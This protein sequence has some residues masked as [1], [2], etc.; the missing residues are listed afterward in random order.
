MFRFVDRQRKPLPCPQ[1][2]H[3]DKVNLNNL[4][5]K[6][7]KLT[8]GEQ[9]LTKQRLLSSGTYGNVY[10]YETDDKEHTVVVKE[11]EDE[12]D[13]TAERDLAQTVGAVCGVVHSVPLDGK[14]I[15]HQ[16]D[17]D[18]EK[19][20]LH[21]DVCAEI[22]LAIANMLDCLW[23]TRGVVYTDVK[24][25]NTLYWCEDDGFISIA[26]GDIGSMEKYKEEEALKEY[27][28]TF[29]LPSKKDLASQRT[30]LLYVE[31]K[32]EELKRLLNSTKKMTKEMTKKMKKKKIKEYKSSIDHL[33]QLRTKT[34]YYD[35]LE[36]LSRKNIPSFL[37]WQCACL[38]FVLIDEKGKQDKRQSLENYLSWES[39]TRYDNHDEFRKFR[40]DLCN[41]LSTKGYLQNQTIARL[42]E[43]FKQP[44]NKTLQ[45]L[46]H[47]AAVVMHSFDE[48]YVAGCTKPGFEFAVRGL[49]HGYPTDKV[50]LCERHF[51]SKLSDM[52]P[53]VEESAGA[54]LKQYTVPSKKRKRGKKTREKVYVWCGPQGNAE[55]RKED[56]WVYDINA[57]RKAAAA[58]GSSAAERYDRARRVP[59]PIDKY[60]HLEMLKALPDTDSEEEKFYKSE[61][62]EDEDT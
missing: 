38:F 40:E 39:W 31:T 41:R 37:A 45:F 12:E 17:G 7:E 22:T 32:L 20:T 59:L 42:C 18:L 19:L 61:E 10:L 49:Q 23:K 60:L 15:M 29:P 52:P 14:I 46:I 47:P 6:E 5:F 11:F 58:K 3:K 26:L 34:K 33:E 48:C 16:Y 8:D 55:H 44:E 36:P 57:K 24:V 2:V 25:E 1:R 9:V 54:Q 35:L 21:I 43:V 13:F 53:Y 56:K 30:H 51:K 27:I 50:H 62:E 28:A 4:S